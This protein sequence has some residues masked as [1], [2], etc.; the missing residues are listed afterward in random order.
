MEPE[1]SLSE[2]RERFVSFAALFLRHAAR[3]IQTIDRRKRDFP[4]GL[5]LT[6]R[7]AQSLGRLLNIENVVDNLKRQPG[8][9]PVAR[10]GGNLSFGAART[11]RPHAHAGAQQSTRLRAM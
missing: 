8:V 6:R 3:L 4:L 10:N 7:L 5:V 2:P 11:D 9:L 1:R